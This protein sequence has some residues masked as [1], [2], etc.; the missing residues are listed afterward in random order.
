MNFLADESVDQQIVDRLRA[1]GHSVVY[2]AEMDPGID[3]KAV[4]NAAN[5]RMALLI[6]ADK[7]FGELVFRQRLIS[8][9][10][11][12]V[13]LAGLSPAGKAETVSLAIREHESELSDAF[14][15]VSPGMFRIRRRT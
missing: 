1:D 6:T 3:D 4:L 9:G 2:V 5:Q 15:V 10:V 13:R 14:S 12:L 11:V 8:M 7:G